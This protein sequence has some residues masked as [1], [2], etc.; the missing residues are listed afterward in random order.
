M[1]PLRPFP[2]AAR[3]RDLDRAATALYPQLYERKRQRMLAS[4]H[5]FFRGSAPLFYEVLAARPDLAEGPPGEGWLVGDMHL[6]NAGAYRTDADRVVFDLNDFDDASIGPSQLDVVRLATSVLLAGRTFKTPGAASIALAER[7]IDAYAEAA[8]AP[9][10]RG[11]PSPSLPSPIADMVAKAGARSRRELL[12]DRAPADRAGRRRFVRGER[13]FDVPEALAAEVPALIDRYVAA[14]GPRAPAHAADWQVE[15][16]AM[17]VAGTGSLGATRIAVLVRD[18]DGDER[19]VEI[20]ESRPPAT[21][22][23][24]PPSPSKAR[25]A[26]QAERVVQGARALADDPPRQLAPV[27]LDERSFAARKLFPQED[28][29]RLETLHAGPKL[30]AVAQTIGRVLG[31]AH[32]RAA[33]R[34]RADGGP[35]EPPAARWSAAEA[36]SLIDRAVE[37]AGIF[38]AVYLAYARK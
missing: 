34:G 14:L 10:S 27:V 26:T 32:A 13:Y 38:E 21:A 6:E 30:D 23:I 37:L 18:R 16:A 1:N 4:P 8:A 35:A 19:I 36:A 20:K 22:A 3:Q 25:W 9:P 28:K 24:L 5:A 29:L 17:R 7:L 33:A 11:L 2:L 12:D 31:A 15:D